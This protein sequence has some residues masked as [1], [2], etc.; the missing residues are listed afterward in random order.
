MKQV[1]AD[2]RTELRLRRMR[3]PTRGCPRLGTCKR[4]A[5]NRSSMAFVG[6][7]RSQSSA[8]LHETDLRK[9]SS[10]EV[11]THDDACALASAAAAGTRMISCMHAQ[12]I[13]GLRAQR[14]QEILELHA[15]MDIRAHEQLAIATSRLPR[16]CSAF[17][18]DSSQ[19]GAFAR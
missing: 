15:C 14:A 17:Q 8:G 9:V 1:H 10:S 4:S 12:E 7:A 13:L 5:F 19:H 3:I 2:T 16:S 18:Q 6:D 11:N